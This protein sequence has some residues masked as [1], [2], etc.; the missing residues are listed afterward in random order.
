MSKKPSL[1]SAT[2]NDV[3]TN[4][5]LDDSAHDFLTTRLT[6]RD[7]PNATI[8]VG[9]VRTVEAGGHNVNGDPVTKIRLDHVEIAFDQKA[10]DDLA[11]ILNRLHKDRTGKTGV[12]ALNP[13]EDTPLDGVD[14]APGDDA[15]EVE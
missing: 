1:A 6:D 11:K 2:P 5:L 9:V 13:P 8:I 4:A 12:D 7:T 10:Y 15:D 14:V 3:E